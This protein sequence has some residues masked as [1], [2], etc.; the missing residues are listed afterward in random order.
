[1]RRSRRSDEYPKGAPAWMT[2]YGDI[3]T[4]CL[5]FFVL[6]YSFSNIDTMK[7][8]R[9]QISIQS[10]L[11]QVGAGDNLLDGS[12]GQLQE[13]IQYTQEMQKLENIKSQLETY[14][15]EQN[16]SDNISV[17]MEERGLVLRFQ[18]S[19]LFNKGKA[20][21][22]GKSFNVLK[23]SAEIFQEIDN[24]IRVEGHTDDLPI[25]TAKYPSNWELSTAR[26][27][28]VLRY[29][30]EQGIQGDRL[31]AVGYSKYH[32]LYEN[33]SEENRR[34]NRRVDIVIIRESLRVNEPK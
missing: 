1:M 24:P 4:L 29:L 28:N 19:V 17:N 9:V 8:N 31:S 12:D 2:T 30:I 6:L 16:L 33:N 10:A 14:L 15:Q 18:D 21:L 20:E 7:W 22:L 26:A 34:K 5:T 27:T 25:N 13:F 32:P 3:V 11:G 23:N